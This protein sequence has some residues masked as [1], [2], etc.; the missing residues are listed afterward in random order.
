MKKIIIIISVLIMY[1]ILGQI[2]DFYLPCPVHFLTGYY[3][4]GCGVTRMI[5]SIIKLD[6]Y[7]AFRYN[8]LLFLF[9]PVIITYLFLQVR[10]ETKGIKNVMNEKRFNKGWFIMV[11]IF[12]I[13]G[14][15]RNTTSFSFLAPINV[16]G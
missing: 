7:Q 11:I 4:P 16:Q 14:V 3:C 9:I 13:Y 2:L 6:F 10:Y 1:F 15:L 8:P 12:I 5:V